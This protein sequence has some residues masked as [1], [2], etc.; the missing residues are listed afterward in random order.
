VCFGLA[1]AETKWRLG[2]ECDYVVE[3]NINAKLAEFEGSDW[4]VHVM[5][6]VYK[7]WD[8]GQG[9][10]LGTG[11]DTLTT[12]FGQIYTYGDHIKSLGNGKLWAGRRFYNRVQLGINDHFLENMDGNGAG[13]EDIELGAAKLSV[14]FMMDP[15]NASNNNRFALPIRVTN[16]KDMP[17]GELSFYVTPSKQL[18]TDD[19]TNP[20]APVAPAEEKG[21]LKVSAYQTLNGLVLGGNTLIGLTYEKQGDY[22]K[23]R[24]AFQQTANFG[25]TAVDFITEFHKIKDTDKWFSIGAR[26]DTHIGGPFRFLAEAGYDTIKPEVGEKSNLSKVTLALAASGGNQAGSRP[27]VRLFLTHAAWNDAAT[28]GLNANTKKVFGDK[29]AGTSIG[30]QG[31]TW[32]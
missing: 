9:G 26:A 2:N 17:N 24:V 11:P 28:A 19:N 15:N 18:K 5:P 23:T 27:T 14:A 21:A 1:G 30:I 12:R 10:T 8:S 20:A 16:I 4:H 7:A 25:P 31:E 32:W 6:S 13:L 29:K 22:K 3:P